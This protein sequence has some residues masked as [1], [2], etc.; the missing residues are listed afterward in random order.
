VGGIHQFILS[1]IQVPL[2]GLF[3]ARDVTASHPAHSLSQL[4]CQLRPV[5]QIISQHLAPDTAPV[6]SAN[7][8]H[9]LVRDIETRGTLPLK[10]VGIDQYARHQNTSV[11]CVGFAVD[12]EPARLWVPGDPIPKEFHEAEAN[13][14]WLSVAHNS[15]FERAIEEH[16]LAQKYNWP[17]APLSR[18]RDTMSMA[19]ACGLPGK[20]STLADVL[21]LAHRKNQGGQRLMFQMSKPRKP[22]KDENPADTFWFDD[23]QRLDRLYS[24]CQEDVEI[25]RELYLRLPSLSASEQTLWELNCKIN[26]HGFHVDRIFAEAAKKIAQ[27]AAPE[28]DQELAEITGGIVTTI[29]QVA[30]L[31]KWLQAQGCALTALDKKTIEQH[32]EAGNLPR[33]V[34]RALEL[35]LGGA[36]AAAKKIE[37]LL[38]R[39]DDGDR[40]RGSF[41]FHGA[42]TGRFS[43]E[44]VQPQNLKKR[45]T[46]DNIDAAIAA[47]TTGD[48]QHVKSLYPKPLAVVGDCT[49]AMICAASGKVLIGADFSSIES[50]I[51]SWIAG[52]EWKIDSYRRH[53]ATRDAADE[54]YRVTAAAIFH[55]QPGAITKE[56]RN[57]GKTCDL[58][59]GY[60]GG[61]A[62]FRKFSDAFSDDE[63][64][65]FNQEWRASH[66][67]IKR[68]W[69]DIDR[70]ALTAVRERGRVVRCGSIAFKSNGTFLQLKLPSGRKISYPFARAV[71]DEQRQHVVFQDN[72]SGKFTETRGYGGIWVENTVSGI[73]RDLLAEAMLRLEG[74]GYLIIL[75]VHDEIVAEVPVG[76]GSTE[77][78]THLMT[79]RPAWAL[80]LPI[81]ASAWTGSRYTK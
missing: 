44:G 66:P 79:R 74:A 35:R 49:R 31:L 37:T 9:I 21:E 32:L 34:R 76:F 48:F 61:V 13:P 29:N 71:G 26:N 78:F 38:V 70:A 6:S 50:R 20:L 4:T 53:D 36:Q 40:V 25:T 59:F 69:Y 47:I 39:A 75:H 64:K 33:Q 62:A 45:G 24:Y 1:L 55:V 27:A 73:A 51:L 68:F 12:D 67:A 54:P 15:A 81:A 52:E 43:A 28:I 60:Q 11:L 10:F 3:G 42:G 23:A 57:L 22:R 2:P 65:I 46:V 58:A 41:R 19:L 77:E 14:D 72:A 56:Q 8:T 63:V 16:V 18:N 80:D 7:H 5:L 30:K 17:I